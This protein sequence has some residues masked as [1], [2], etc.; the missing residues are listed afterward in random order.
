MNIFS[1]GKESKKVFFTSAFWYKN[2]AKQLPCVTFSLNRLIL[3]IS[4]SQ[5]VQE[6][7]ISARILRKNYTKKVLNSNCKHLFYSLNTVDSRPLVLFNR[8]INYFFFS[9]SVFL[10]K[11][12][13]STPYSRIYANDTVMNVVSVLEL[14]SF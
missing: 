6:W 4:I 11:W 3:A 7:Y 1:K 2:G 13:R 9:I 5:G 10:T 14:K 12:N 8:K